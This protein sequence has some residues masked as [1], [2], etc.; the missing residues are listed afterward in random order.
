MAFATLDQ[1]MQVIANR[2]LAYCRQ[3]YGGNG[4]KTEEAIA[5]EIAWRPTIQT[6]PDRFNIVAVE[7]ADNL[8]P[9]ALKGAAHDITH[10]DSPITVYQA[11]SLTTYQSDPK[12][13]KAKL[14]RKYGFGII[15]VDDDGVVTVQHTCIPLAQHISSEELDGY[16]S[17]L[18]PG[19]KVKF[20][21]AHTT[22]LANAGQGLQQAG[23]I[24]EAMIK[25]IAKQAV[26]DKVITA[27]EAKGTVAEVI[28]A[29]YATKQFKDYRAALGDARGFIKE[30]RNVASHPQKSA[31]QVAEKIRKC[32]AGFVDGVNVACNLKKVMHQ[33]G[34]KVTIHIV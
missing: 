25:C 1:R 13:A 32:K 30:S 12:Q 34:Y 31:K 2:V 16:L 33:L 4:L 11:C 19:L 10:Y 6:R 20:R 27:T 9:E 3:R 8:F 14:L 15:T 29:L 17:G 24:V 21:Q 26:E 28:D 7:V 23:Q 18:T 5:P 22:Y